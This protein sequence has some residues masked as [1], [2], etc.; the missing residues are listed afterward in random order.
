VAIGDLVG[1]VPPLQA[2]VHGEDYHGIVDSFLYGV[3]LNKIAHA[4]DETGSLF[5]LPSGS[6]PVLQAEIYTSDRW[7]RLASG[8]REVGALLLL[9]APADAPGLADLIETLGGAVIVGNAAALLPPETRVIAMASAPAAY[10][11]R[12][13]VTPEADVTPAEATEAAVAPPPRRSWRTPLIAAATIAAAGLGAYLLFGGGSGAGAPADSAAA[14]GAATPRPSSAAPRL[15][16]A[17]PHDS[18]VAT[19]YS[20]EV[21]LANTVAGANDRLQTRS[22]Q[23]RLPAGTLS[24]LLVG[25]DNARWYKV[26]AGAFETREGADSL[27]AKLRRDGMLDATQG[28]VVRAPLAFLLETDVPAELVQSQLRAYTSP[29]VAPYALV[30]ATGYAN[31]YAG[32]FETPEQAAL[33]AETLQAARLAPILVYRTGR[34]L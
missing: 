31:I 16:A 20:V 1:E 28:A 21:V 26:T 6:E 27:L 3:S 8:F 29:G 4:V 9:V 22:G 30:N 7:R 33:L 11:G 12:R 24:P 17:N 14:A 18:L 19:S 2:F 13:P 10:T 15:E 5:I 25:G 34:M 32:A 23:P